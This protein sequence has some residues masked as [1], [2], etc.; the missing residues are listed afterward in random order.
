MKITKRKR[1]VPAKRK[2]AVPAKRKR[3]VPACGSVVENLDRK[4]RLSL[5]PKETVIVAEDAPLLTMVIQNVGLAVFEVTVEDSEP[6]LLMPGKL[7]M[8]TVYGKVT[9]ENWDDNP[10]IAE[11]E[12]LPRTKS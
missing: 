1:A 7:S 12:I 6:V 3:A 10:G 2:R 9:I 8:M 5:S 4:W 11:F